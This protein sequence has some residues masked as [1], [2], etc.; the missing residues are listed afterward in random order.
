M[1]KTIDMIQLF[2]GG[3][4]CNNSHNVDGM[5]KAILAI[6][7]HNSAT[8]EIHDHSYCPT[9]EDS[10][11]KCSKVVAKNQPPPIHKPPCIPVDLA[12]H[13]KPVFEDLSK[14]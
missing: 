1:D 12:P 14:Q 13:V 8:E 10:W 9:G 6:F 5:Y 4:I 7:F 3:A 2:Y 11:C